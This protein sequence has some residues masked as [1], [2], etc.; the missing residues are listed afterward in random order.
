MRR[1]KD[2]Y[3]QYNCLTSRKTELE[4]R[5]ISATGMYKAAFPWSSLEEEQAERKHHKTLPSGGGEEVAGNVWISPED[6]K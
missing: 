3:A 1:S 2:G 4:S 5:Y 6:G